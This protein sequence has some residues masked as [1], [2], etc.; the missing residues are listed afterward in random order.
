MCLCLSCQ[1][2]SH[3]PTFNRVTFPI[4]TYPIKTKISAGLQLYPPVLEPPALYIV[5]CKKTILFVNY[6]KR[7]ITIREQVLFQSTGIPRFTLLMWRHKKKRG[8]KNLVNQGYLVVLKGRKI[9]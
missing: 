4:S 7:V 5:Q 1:N 9:G 3:N 6:I 8:S 2:E